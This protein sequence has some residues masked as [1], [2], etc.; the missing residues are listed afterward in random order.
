MVKYLGYDILWFPLCDTGSRLHLF[1]QNSG[2]TLVAKVMYV[3]SPKD[4]TCYGVID[5]IWVVDYHLL[6]ILVL[7][8][9][10][11]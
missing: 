10:W 8:C 11:V 2:V 1:T 9:D 5:E 3:A 7:K 6:K 4:M